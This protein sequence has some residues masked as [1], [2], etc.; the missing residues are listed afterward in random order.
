[1]PAVAPHVAHEAHAQWSGVELDAVH[2]ANHRVGHE[3]VIL[4]TKEEIN[5]GRSSDIVGADLE[6]LTELGVVILVGQLAAG[7]LIEAITFHIMELA[8]LVSDRNLE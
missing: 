4:D 3:E 5:I 2:V 8:K 1:M 6:L 7:D